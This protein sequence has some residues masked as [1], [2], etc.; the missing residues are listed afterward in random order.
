MNLKLF[1]PQTACGGPGRPLS[2]RRRLAQRSSRSVE[3]A[4]GNYLCLVPYLALLDSVG[5]RGVQTG[6]ILIVLSRAAV[7]LAQ[8]KKYAEL[9]RL[10]ILGMPELRQGCPWR[11][12]WLRGNPFQWTLP[13]R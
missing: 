7:A 10:D 4:M 13:R 3:M 8:P 9:A 2:P 1:L 5:P 12:K 11:N 6:T